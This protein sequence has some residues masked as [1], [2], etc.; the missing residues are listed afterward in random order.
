MGNQRKVRS[1]RECERLVESIVNGL[2]GIIAYRVSLDTSHAEADLEATINI[3]V[4][5][6]EKDY[7]DFEMGTE[8]LSTATVDEIE[9]E[10]KSLIKDQDERG[11]FTWN[12]PQ[13]MNNRNDTSIGAS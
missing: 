9:A 11:R 4:Q 5:T 12:K 13:S 10:I 2:E 1:W 7:L 8:W 3:G 6:A